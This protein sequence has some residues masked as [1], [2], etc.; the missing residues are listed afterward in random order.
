MFFVFRIIKGLIGLIFKLILLPLVLVL[1]IVQCVCI[2]AAHL[3]ALFFNLVGGMFFN[4]VGGIFIVT[5]ILSYYFELEPID[6]MWRMIASGTA[7]YILPML[8]RE[9]AVWTALI[10]ETLMIRLLT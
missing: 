1:T 6:V 2:V 9:F 3:S 8:V 7:L 5:G 4:L 10:K